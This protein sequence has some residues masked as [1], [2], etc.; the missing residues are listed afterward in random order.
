MPTSRS[1]PDG[2]SQDSILVRLDGI[3]GDLSD[4]E[5]DRFVSRFPVQKLG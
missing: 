3:R 5:L 1:P 4:E 2:L